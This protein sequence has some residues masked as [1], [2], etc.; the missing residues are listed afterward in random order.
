MRRARRGRGAEERGRRSPDSSPALAGE[1]DMD[2]VVKVVTPDGIGGVSTLGGG[3]DVAGKVLVGFDGDDDGAALG[4]AELVGAGGDFGDDVLRGIVPDGLDGVEAEAVEV[5]LAQPV[6]RV[7]DDEAADVS[8]AGVVVIDGIAPGSFVAGGEV[9]AE[10]REV[11]SLVAEVVV[12]DIEEDGEAALVGGIDEAAKRGGT[13]VIGLH[14]VE[15]DAI[16]APVAG[17]GTA[18]TGMSSMAVMPRSWR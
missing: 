5:I 2:G 6:E 1:Q 11:I 8:A 18:L 15:A 4:G 12:D 17:P 13:A 9:R 16:V 7:F 14:G 10:L 3:E